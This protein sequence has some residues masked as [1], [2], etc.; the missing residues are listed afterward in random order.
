MSRQSKAIQKKII[1]K[2]ITAMHLS[3]TRGPSRTKP[4][5]GKVNTMKVARIAALAA[6]AR[7]AETASNSFAPKNQKVVSNKHQQKRA[8]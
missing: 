4:L 1:A 8:A 6:K 2:Q 3:G 5:H 7:E